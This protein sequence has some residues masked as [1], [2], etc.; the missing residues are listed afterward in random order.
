MKAKYDV[1]NKYEYIDFFENRLHY[2]KKKSYKFFRKKEYDT[3]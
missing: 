1:F 3:R 2:Q